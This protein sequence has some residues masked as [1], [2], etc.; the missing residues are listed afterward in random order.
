MAR[1][2]IEEE[3]WQEVMPLIA[4]FG[5]QDKAIGT[6]IRFW[7]FAQTKHKS[8]KFIS[9]QDFK[10]QGF[11][12]SLIPIFAK[13]TP[14]GIQ[15]KGSEK[16]FSWLKQKKDAGKA[17]G[18]VSATRNRDEKGKL[19][20]KV[21]KQNPSKT[22]RQPS[23][24]QASYSYSSS[25]SFSPS[26]NG[27]PAPSAPRGNPVV[28]KYI[29]Q[30]AKKYSG[31]KPSLAGKE[32]SLLKSLGGLE[33]VETACLMVQVYFQMPDQWF[34]TKHYDVPT[35]WENRGKVKAA[36]HTGRAD[37]GKKSALEELQEL[38]VVNSDDTSICKT[39]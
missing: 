11:P 7:R 17:G 19:L 28:G 29:E 30:F 5:D 31:A 4:Q 1:I 6:V 16:H 3:F 10:A 36:L 8:G 23:T 2:N 21:P 20:P 14:S 33:G 39:N 12:E 9:E 38:G 32:L 15:A 18:K 13:R 22:K 34:Q 27:E 35:L 37:P 24:H 26:L 25:Y